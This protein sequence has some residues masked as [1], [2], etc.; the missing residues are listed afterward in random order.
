MISKAFGA[1]SIVV[2]QTTWLSFT[3]TVALSPYAGLYADYYFSQD[4]AQ[5]VGLTTVPLLQG[6][7][8]RVTGGINARFAGGASIGA[9]GEFGGIGL[10]THIW[11]WTAR[12]SIPF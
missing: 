5:T 11:I 9:G 4:D 10:S 7:A 12:G 6:F 2:G 8:A 3:I 1:P